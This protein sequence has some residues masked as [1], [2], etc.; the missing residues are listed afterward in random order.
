MQCKSGDMLADTIML[1]LTLA[2]TIMLHLMMTNCKSMCLQLNAVFCLF[3]PCS[4]SSPAVLQGGLTTSAT[5]SSSARKGGGCTTR[6]GGGTIL[7]GGGTTLGSWTAAVL[8]AC[9][10]ITNTVYIVEAH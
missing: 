7:G 2:D 4:S 6:T 5:R 1:H 9:L 3:G 10:A 8:T